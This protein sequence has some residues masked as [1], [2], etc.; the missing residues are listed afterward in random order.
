MIVDNLEFHIRA[1]GNASAKSIR[2]LNGEVTR[3]GKNSASAAKHTGKLLSALARVAFYRA[4]RSVIKAITDAFKEGSE[5]AYF[6]A[7]SINDELATALDNLA[8]KNFTATNQ[9]GAAWATLLATLTP[10]L[11]QIIGL[12]TRVAQIITQ[13]FSVLGGRTTYLKAIDYT[14]DWAQATAGGAASAKEWK[15]QLM[16]FDEI[17]RLEEP[18]DSGGGGGSATPDYSKMFELAEIS[19]KIANIVETVKAH[20]EDLQLFLSGMALGMGAILLFSGANVPLG[21]ALMVIGGYSLTQGIIPRW[22]EII[23]SMQSVM[24]TIFLVVS[25]GLVGLGAILFLSGANLP[26]G[27]GL[28]AAGAVMLGYTVTMNWKEIPD[29]IKKIVGEIGAIVSVAL[30]GFGAILAFTGVAI[31]VG[32]ALMAAGAVG[33]VATKTMAWG[34]LTDDIKREIG[35]LGGI[36]G[37]SLMVIGAILAFTGAGIPLGLG[38]IAAGATSLGAVAALDYNSVSDGITG[39]IGKISNAMQDLGH[40][41]DNTMQKLLAFFGVQ[42]APT[43]ESTPGYESGYM[44]F[45][46]GGF[47]TGQVFVAREAGPELVGT[48]GGRTAVANNDQIVEAVSQGVFQAVVSAM[49]NTR[50]DSDVNIYLDGKKIAT[51]TSK[52]QRQFAQMAHA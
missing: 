28:L 7:K 2:N 46:D 10:I 42:G 29:K 39:A 4:I 21:L 40:W 14:K 51:T 35:L 30:I 27:L 31:P 34:Y 26:V 43:V 9:L 36:L 17:N 13:F 20:M 33:L 19:P 15:N 3:L 11:T 24:S 45:A 41:I 37:G 5:N 1:T 44:G 25:G 22:G 23:S 48:I 38:L 32:V 8:T 16:G 12:L 50:S 47:P 18:S 6:F 49:G 52:Y